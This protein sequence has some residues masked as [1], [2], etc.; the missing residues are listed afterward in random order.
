MKLILNFFAFLS[1]KL[2]NPTSLL[3]LLL[4]KRRD[5]PRLD[6][7]G[8]LRETTLTKDLRVSQR[9]QVNDGSGVRLRREVFATGF[10]RDEGPQFIKVDNGV[11]EMI[12]LLTEVPHT[13]FSEVSWMVLVEIGAV[14]VLT[15]SHTTTTGMF[16]VLPDTTVSGTY[17][18]A[19]LSGFR[20]SGRHGVVVAV[21]CVCRSIVSC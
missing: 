16:S 14:M 11:P 8:D 20:Q 21:G 15:T 1:N 2:N 18:T 9:E 6:D 4:R 3:D 17:V 5:I 7:D 12:A 19:V 13:D 10:G